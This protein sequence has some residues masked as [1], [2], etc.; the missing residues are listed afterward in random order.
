MLT[1]LEALSGGGAAILLRFA[2]LLALIPVLAVGDPAVATTIVVDDFSAGTTDLNI[3][4]AAPPTL[5]ENQVE[6]GLAGVLGGSRSVT[7]Q[8]IVGSSGTSRN[9]NGAVDP[10]EQQFLY[11]SGGGVIGNLTLGY[12]GNGGGLNASI[13]QALDSFM[14]EFIEGDYSSTRTIPV[15]M[16][17]TAS[18]NQSGSLQQTLA[19][20]QAP[21]SLEFPVA[22][23]SNVN[24]MAFS[25][26]TLK[27]IQI[28]FSP[29]ETSADFTLGSVQ[30]VPEPSTYAM[31]LAGV[32]CG[33]YLVRR[34]RRRA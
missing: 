34:C 14:I 18:N 5:T 1:R 27:S 4:A 8:K 16:T 33:G 3:T 30:I 26:N 10:I 13:V 17:I 12:D 24:L 32:A 21:V 20:S 28:R 7:I 19:V 2:P 22:D 11:S 29:T 15:L 9:V 25:T 31:A 6:T 23:F